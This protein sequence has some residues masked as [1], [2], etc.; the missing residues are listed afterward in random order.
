MVVCRVSPFVTSLEAVSVKIHEPL[1]CCQDQQLPVDSV[2]R[3]RQA[4]PQPG[5]P[6]LLL[7][8]A[9]EHFFFMFDRL[10]FSVD[11]LR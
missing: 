4:N 11:T 3:R 5:L 8:Q 6:L 10:C 9:F 7:H 1:H 2:Y